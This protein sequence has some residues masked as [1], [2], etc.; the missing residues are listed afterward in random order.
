MFMSKGETPGMRISISPNKNIVE[1][2]KNR[3]GIK[4]EKNVYKNRSL[5]IFQA[6]TKE[7]TLKIFGTSPNER[8][9]MLLEFSREKNVTEGIGNK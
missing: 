7:N 4:E 9:S 8:I 1:G 5:E 3:L 6:H 2:L